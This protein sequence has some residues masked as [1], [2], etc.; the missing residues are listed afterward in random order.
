MNFAP[1]RLTS[2][3]DTII[4]G[5][6]L[7]LGIA[8]R[9]APADVQHSVASAIR[10][11]ALK[12]F[13]WI[14]D[15][16]QSLRAS[17]RNYLRA[18][19]QRDSAL[20]RAFTAQSLEEENDRLRELLSLSRRLP[21]GHVAAAVLHQAMPTDRF[22]L[23]LSAGSDD[24]VEPAAPVVAPGGL[25]GVVRS[26]DRKASVAIVWSHPDFRVSA[27]TRGGEV[28]GIVAPHG[29]E[30]PNEL[31]LELR[32]VPYREKVPPGT[33]I[34]TSGVGGT[35]G[36]YPRG[37]PIGEVIAVAEEEEGWARTYSVRPAVHPARASHVII[38]TGPA[39]G[40][41]SAFAPEFR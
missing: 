32:G 37:I 23:V 34:Y 1:D 21:V 12:P 35:S 30:G 40:L 26:V 18:I 4:F 41:G 11:S 33:T 31:L 6:C 38:L 24:G 19:A 17:R 20:L 3:R 10:N 25:L 2:R 15:Q 28:F 16:T 9:L 39:L 14:Q 27:M 29:V 22:T 5:I 13:L 8:A 7:L 36:V